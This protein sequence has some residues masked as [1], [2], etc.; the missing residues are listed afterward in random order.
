MVD[1]SIEQWSL[2]VRRRQGEVVRQRLIQ[3][4]LLDTELKIRTNGEFVIFPVRVEG[5]G[6]TRDL[7]ELQEAPKSLPR[8]ELIGGIAIMQD[9]DID[10]ATKLLASRPSLHTVLYA[11]SAVGGIFR[12][13]QFEV[14]AGIPTTKT[15]YTEYGHRYVID[16]SLAYFSA[17][18]SAERQRV[19]SH[20][21]EDEWVLDMFAGVGPFAITLS[22]KVGMVIASDINPNAVALMVENIHRNRCMNVIPILADA[23]RLNEIL[24]WKFDRIIMNHPLESQHFLRTAF[25]L[26]KK[27]GYVHFY[28]LQ[29]RESEFLPTINQYPTATVVEHTIR[30]YSP[31]QWHA[32]YD[33]K[34]G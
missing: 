11:L 20:V 25:N 12:T 22:S 7:F 2:R 17:R 24:Y 5:E 34:V 4:R 3:A 14:L 9:R 8:H 21:S 23:S 10:A 19:L 6:K 15:S 31:T 27:G 18:L 1:I 26:C 16:L 32:V 28:V 13:K 30:T 29:S 33:I